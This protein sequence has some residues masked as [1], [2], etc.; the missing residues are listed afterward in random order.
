MSCLRL[1]VWP[2]FHIIVGTLVHNTGTN[3][4]FMKQKPIFRKVMK[5]IH[6]IPDNLFPSFIPHY[7]LTICFY[8]HK[9]S[10]NGSTV[11]S[12]FSDHQ[13]IR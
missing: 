13:I 11:F 10:E 3:N 7:G 6:I 1:Q 12:Y 2:L 8:D 5:R 4:T 9:T